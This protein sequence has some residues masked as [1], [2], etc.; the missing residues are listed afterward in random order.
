MAGLV[1]DQCFGH[2]EGSGELKVR[3]SFLCAGGGHAFK[4]CE[5]EDE[6]EGEEED[7]R[8]R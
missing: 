3:A 6:E 7:Q 5:K 4:E 1:P 8:R 2:V